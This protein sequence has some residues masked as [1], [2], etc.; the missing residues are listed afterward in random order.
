MVSQHTVLLIAAAAL[1]GA[2]VAAQG[3]I[4]ARM[5]VH[6]GGPLQTAFIAFGLGLLTIVLLNLAAGSSIP[7]PAQLRTAPAWTWAGGIIGA[8]MV[9]LS[10]IAIPRLGV[11]TFMT[12]VICG[13]LLAAI[14][15]DHFGAFGLATR[16][17]DMTV[18]TGAALL[19]A[20]AWLIMHR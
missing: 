4:F 18:L 9:L 3:P 16:S 7:S 6:A 12:A 11:G 19:L 15:F 5:A 14:L 20:G 13:Q 1:A 17:V 8:L 10:I 2:L